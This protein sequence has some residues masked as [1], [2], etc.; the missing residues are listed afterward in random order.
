VRPRIAS[1]S[2]QAQQALLNTCLPAGRELPDGAVSDTT[3]DEQN[4]QSWLPT[5]ILNKLKLRRQCR[6]KI[7]FETS[8][9]LSTDRHTQ[10]YSEEFNHTKTSEPFNIAIF[11]KNLLKLF[12]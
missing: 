7:L 9:G 8:T 10:C 2:G 5:Y 3:D 6:K 11:S 1:L 12:I 4:Y